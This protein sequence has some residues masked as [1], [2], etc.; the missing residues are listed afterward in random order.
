[1]LPS[2]RVPRVCPR[3]MVMD[4]ID[5]CIIAKPMLDIIYNDLFK[6]CITVIKRRI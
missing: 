5:T 1:M 3:G 4:E 6:C 2:S